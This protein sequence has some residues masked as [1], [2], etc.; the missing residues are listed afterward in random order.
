[1]I[2]KGKLRTRKNCAIEPLARQNIKKRNE[3][4]DGDDNDHAVGEEEASATSFQRARNDDEGELC[5]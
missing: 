1:M 4:E 5:A 2:S 3:E